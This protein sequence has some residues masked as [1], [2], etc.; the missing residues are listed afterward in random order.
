[1]TGGVEQVRVVLMTAP[2]QESGEFLARE[3]VSERLAACGNVIPG[4][5]S[6]YWWEGEIEEDDEVLVVLKT[7]QERVEA[8]VERARAL[9][10]YDV[11]EVL[12]LPVTAGNR[13]YG[14]W[15]VRESAPRAEE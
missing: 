12:A 13:E 4:I 10:P 2:N 7:A 8:L 6:V 5:V 9:H 11:P 3:L 15:V 1:M 14:G